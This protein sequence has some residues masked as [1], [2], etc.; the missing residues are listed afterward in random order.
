MITAPANVIARPF[1]W[2][3]R[4]HP[5]RPKY[6]GNSRARAG[7]GEQLSKLQEKAARKTRPN[8]PDPRYYCMIG[9]LAESKI[10]ERS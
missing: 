7:S 1:T 3:P 4:H 6:S 10:D 2:E 8:F 9:R 5:T